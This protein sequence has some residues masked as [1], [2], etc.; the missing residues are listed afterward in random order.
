MNLCLNPENRYISLNVD[1]LIISNKNFNLILSKKDF[2][3]LKHELLSGYEID[4]MFIK[5]EIV[6]Y[7]FCDF[8]VL[9]Q[10]EKNLSKNLVL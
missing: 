7:D 8:L 3:K 1:N 2:A 6:V 9:N 10:E 5:L 4:G